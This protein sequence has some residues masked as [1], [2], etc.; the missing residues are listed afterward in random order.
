MKWSCVTGEARGMKMWGSVKTT[1]VCR[2]KYTHVGQTWEASEGIKN[3]KR[4]QN[5]RNENF[6][7][8]TNIV[9][10]PSEDRHGLESQDIGKGQGWKLLSH[11]WPSQDKRDYSQTNILLDY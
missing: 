7:K 11:T 2:N 8:A 1:R 4:V 9:D 5:K 10:R 3:D 6:G